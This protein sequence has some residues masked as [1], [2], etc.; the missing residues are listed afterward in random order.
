MTDKKTEPKPMNKFLNT[1]KKVIIGVIAIALLAL[2]GYKLFGSK[3]ATVQYQTS[4]AAKGTMVSSVTA[5]GTVAAGDTTNVTTTA[6]GFV[7]TLYVKIGDT[8]TQGEKIAD[9]TLDRD[10]QTRLASAYSSYLQSQNQITT[11][12]TAMYSLQSSMFSKWQTFTNLA[13]NSTYTNPDGSPNTG[14]RTLPQFIEAQDDWFTTQAQYQS[15]QNVIAQAQASANNASLTY[16]EAQPTIVAPSAGV[17]T[18]LAIAPGVPVTVSTNTS[19]NS[20]SNSVTPLTVA[21]IRLP[22]GHTLAV[23]DLSEMDAA[24]VKPG[25]KVTLTLDALANQTFTGKVLIVNTEGAVSSGVTTYPATIAFDTSSDSIYTNMGVNASIITNVQDNVI[26]VPSAAVT[27]TGGASTVKV[28]KNGQVSTV[29][30]T[31]G[32]SNDTQTAV[33]TGLNDG[34]TVVTGTTTAKTTASGAA[35]AFSSIGGRGG[36]GGGGGAV[37]VTTGGR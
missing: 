37:R 18:N 17:I 11:A 8:V 3:T 6:S 10:G 4:T 15:Q 28:M 31:I 19:S 33:L 34:D 21:T 2:T 5:S 9:V 12:Q 35:S 30:V 1:P 20:S 13:E 27:T 32:D 26:L 24:K 7:S 25:Q 29:S 23:V 22:Q 16:Q 36:F 14:N